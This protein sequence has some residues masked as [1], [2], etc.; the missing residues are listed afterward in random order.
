MLCFGPK[1]FTVKPLNSTPEKINIFPCV[2]YS[3]EL[4]IGGLVIIII[5]DILKVGSIDKTIW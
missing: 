1:Y 5:V 3:T 2:L 4:F